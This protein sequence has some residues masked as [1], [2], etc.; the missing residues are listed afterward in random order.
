MSLSDANS[1]IVTHEKRGCHS[2]GWPL[3]CLEA[4]LPVF[5]VEV[6]VDEVPEDVRPIGQRE[7]V[8]ELRHSQR[9]Q[10]TEL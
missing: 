5:T 8:K 7:G 3:T 2:A 1:D 4:N 6:G 9:G 10:L